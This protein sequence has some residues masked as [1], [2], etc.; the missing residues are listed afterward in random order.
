MGWCCY[1]LNPTLGVMLAGSTS[2]PGLFNGYKSV[3]YGW[4]WERTNTVQVL[5]WHMKKI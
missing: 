1:V 2:L 3:G 5:R 4:Q